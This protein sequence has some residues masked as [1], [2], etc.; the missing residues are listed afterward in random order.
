MTV[1][2]GVTHAQV[3]HF[4]FFLYNPFQKLKCFSYPAQTDSNN[5]VKSFFDG[6]ESRNETVCFRGIVVRV[7]GLLKENS[8]RFWIM[9]G[10][11]S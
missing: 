8:N 3:T 7:T 2:I 6:V 4:L 9:T 5:G 10:A 11:V 1:S